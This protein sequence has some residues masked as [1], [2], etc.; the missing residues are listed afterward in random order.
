MTASVQ[1]RPKHP[2]AHTLHLGEA[3]VLASRLRLLALAAL[4]ISAACLAG[5]FAFQ[6]LGGLQPCPLCIAQRWAHAAVIL[7][8]L[9]ALLRP[10]VATLGFTAI[11]GLNALVQAIRHV[12]IEQHWWATECTGLTGAAD[13][14]PGDL[15]AQIMAASLVRCDEIAWQMAGI[16]MAGWNGIVSAGIV[17]LGAWGAWQARSLRRLRS[18]VWPA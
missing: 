17:A 9:A 18:P 12:G 5:A 4:A 16:S 8:A 1:P 2:Q 10:G 15:F 3:R 7:A 11:A 14:A 13:Q 6:Y